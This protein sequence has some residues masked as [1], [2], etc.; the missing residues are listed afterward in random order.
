MKP[1]D[2]QLTLIH[3]SNVTDFNDDV[4]FVNCH[5]NLMQKR[6]DMAKYIGETIS[7]YEK[8]YT[9]IAIDSYALSSINSCILILEPNK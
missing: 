8:D 9:I 3:K 7:F 5:F 1:T 4:I 2:C 6:D